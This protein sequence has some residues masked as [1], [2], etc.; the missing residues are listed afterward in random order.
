MNNVL[1][2]MPCYNLNT[3]AGHEYMYTKE[4]V[5]S[6]PE[7]LVNDT[8]DTKIYARKDVVSSIADELKC[9]RYFTHVSYRQ[10]DGFLKK[11][12][13]LIKR[14]RKWYQENKKM[15]C[16]QPAGSIIFVHSFSI[17][18]TWQWIKL[19]H[20]CEKRNI[21][22]K[23]VFRYSERL[24][25]RYLRSVHRRICKQLKHGQKVTF[26]TDSEELKIEY[27]RSC[28]APFVVL[29]VMAETEVVDFTVASDKGKS[30]IKVISYLGAARYDK[31][32][33]LLPSLIEKSLKKNTNLQFVIQASVPGTQYHDQPCEA[34]LARIEKLSQFYVG[35]I[36]LIKDS[37]DQAMYRELLRKTHILLLPY[38]GDSYK[39][40]TSG[41][42][43]EAI[44]NGIPCLVPSDT[45][46]S[47]EL[48]K[49]GGGV[50][51]SPK[52]D[53]S[54]SNCFDTLIREYPLY[55]RK[56][57]AEMKSERHKHGSVAQLKLILRDDN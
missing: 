5:N 2:V 6:L 29:P 4:I 38:I 28:D 21:K 11:I 52:N 23:L 33:H 48:S 51:F 17:Y 8:L 35:N 42:L 1:F 25:P 16:S 37:V 41:I 39:T 30:G 54:L 13:S 31:G 43:I 49:T 20:L 18:S 57:I 46:L 45:W 22:L 19:I 15:I 7:R 47:R 26:F 55:H 36:K 14:E 3:Y 9:L 32:F 50:E 44:T 10:D 27:E 40:Q 56:A 12:I 34:A 24:L 53:A